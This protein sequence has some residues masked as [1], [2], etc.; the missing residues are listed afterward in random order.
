MTDLMTGINQKVTDYN[1]YLK[2]IEE[3]SRV[4][5]FSL[6]R[7]QRAF[8]YMCFLK[9][10]ESLPRMYKCLLDHCTM[11]VAGLFNEKK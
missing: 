6:T 8:A 4:S 11:N 10:Y 2:A 3:C 1:T 7:V 5:D 9:F